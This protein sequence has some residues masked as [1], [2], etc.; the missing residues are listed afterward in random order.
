MVAVY[1]LLLSSVYNASDF[2]DINPVPPYF[3]T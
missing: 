1:A 3:F 2:S